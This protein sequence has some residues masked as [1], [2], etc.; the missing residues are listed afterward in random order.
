MTV[1]QTAQCG[2]GI[3]AIYC[4]GHDNSFIYGVRY[5]DSFIHCSV[6]GFSGSLGSFRGLVG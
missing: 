5:M 2:P 6:R 4:L 1:S 3:E